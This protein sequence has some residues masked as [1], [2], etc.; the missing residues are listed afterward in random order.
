V[1]SVE[2]YRDLREVIE[3]REKE[4]TTSREGEDVK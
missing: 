4:K 2:E 3:A 1:Q